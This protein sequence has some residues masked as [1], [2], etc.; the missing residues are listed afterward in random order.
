MK[1]SDGPFTVTV[2]NIGVIDSYPNY[3]DACKTY[4]DYKRQSHAGIGRAAG[5]RVVLSNAA[6][7]CL[8]EYQGADG[9]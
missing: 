8:M 1:R 6:G 4:G 9:E 2:G 5:E 3:I 7:D